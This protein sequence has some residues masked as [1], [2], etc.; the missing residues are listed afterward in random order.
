MDELQPCLDLEDPLK[1]STASQA[2]LQEIQDVLQFQQLLLRLP[3][4][5]VSNGTKRPALA[6]TV[7]SVL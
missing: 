6:F 5:R 1:C 3:K 7:L 4:L 2:M